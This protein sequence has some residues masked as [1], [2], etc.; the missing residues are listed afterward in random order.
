MLRIGLLISC[1]LA[2][3]GSA[4]TRIGAKRAN[5]NNIM[6]FGDGAEELRIFNAELVI[7]RDFEC[8]VRD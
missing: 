5:L 2:K 1:R 6:I 7:A 3:F 4:E 8:V